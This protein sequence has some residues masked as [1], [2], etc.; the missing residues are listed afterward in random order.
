MGCDSTERREGA[1][2]RKCETIRPS[3]DVAS[4][5]CVLALTISASIPQAL[6]AEPGARLERIHYNNSG[7]TVDLGVGLWAWPMPMDWD[8]DGDLDLLVACPD[9]PYNGV[10]FFENP[11]GKGAKFPV[12][13][14]GKRLGSAT[15][16]MTS[17]W[18]AP[19]TSVV[20]MA[21]AI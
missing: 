12:F 4:R 2:T 14:L 5:L 20:E 11:A 21:E 16:D 3:T 1:R 15:A 18:Y 10:Y 13:K 17:A 7:L 6:A 19:G 8:E 9:K